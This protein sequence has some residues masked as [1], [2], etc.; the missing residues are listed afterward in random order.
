MQDTIK[1]LKSAFLPEVLKPG[2]LL[3]K[4]DIKYLTA[5]GENY[6]SILLAVDISIN[7]TSTGKTETVR[8][9]A[10]TVPKNDFIKNFFMSSLTFKKELNFYS[11]VIPTLRAFQYDQG[12]E[13]LI[14]FTADFYG[15]RLSLNPQLQHADEDA[16]ILMENLGAHQYRIIDRMIG[17]DF[18]TA[19]LIIKVSDS[20][21]IKLITNFAC[22]CMCLMQF[23]VININK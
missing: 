8:A 23:Q 3:S 22:F 21:I 11:T 5:P 18:E 20:F 15:G 6:G 1:D 17:F 16:V 10:K 4:T 12:M 9:V 19:C 14:S 2:K 7:D 13:N